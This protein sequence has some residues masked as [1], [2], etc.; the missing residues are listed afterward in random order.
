MKRLSESYSNWLLFRAKDQAKRSGKRNA[1]FRKERTQHR[2]KPKPRL[3]HAW[4][5]DGVEQVIC[6]KGPIF[7]PDVLCLDENLTQTLEFLS[8]SRERLAIVD[9]AMPQDLAWLTKTK[10]KKLRRVDT[11]VDFSKI[12]KISTS[13]AVILAALYDRAG[14]L[15]GQAPPTLNLDEWSDAAFVTLYEIGFFEIVGLVSETEQRYSDSRSGHN[16]TM[17][18]ISGS[19]GNELRTASEKI[20]QLSSYIEDGVPIDNDM[21]AQLSS[22]L[23]EAMINVARHAYGYGFESR[24]AQVKRWWISASADRADRSVTIVVYDQGASIPWTLPKQT[25]SSMF[26]SVVGKAIGLLPDVAYPF[27]ADYIEYAM[28]SGRSGTGEPGRGEGLPQ[29]KSFIDFC[30]GGSLSIMSRG[31]RCTYDR[32][33][34]LQKSVLPIPVEG[35]MIEW[36]LFLPGRKEELYG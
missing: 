2:R 28:G 35:T 26:Q 18:L 11:F 7:P 10:G 24:Y 17:R 29:M 12:K 30:G 23:G 13:V 6:L 14:K 25:W 5:G 16:R 8:K 32:T 27:D 4:T 21:M 34:G 19:N 31:G 3:V 9:G 1:E 20:L 33:A 36:K 22:V 15:I